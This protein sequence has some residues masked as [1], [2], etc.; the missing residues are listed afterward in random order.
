MQKR[1]Y[2]K[3][4]FGNENSVQQSNKPTNNNTNNSYISNNQ[5]SKHV[6]VCWNCIKKVLFSVGACWTQILLFEF[7][8]KKPAEMLLLETRMANSNKTQSTH[9]IVNDNVTSD[10]LDCWTV[11]LKKGSLP[12]TK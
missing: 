1:I 7:L 8:D 4:I 10:M 9:L 5:Y 11:G 6:G 2:I 12:K 3:K